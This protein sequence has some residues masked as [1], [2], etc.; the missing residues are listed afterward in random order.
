M[1]HLDDLAEKMP[2]IYKGYARMVKGSL[3]AALRVLKVDLKKGNKIMMIGEILARGI[4]SYGTYKAV[5]QHNE[6]I[7]RYVEVKRSH[8][9][10]NIDKIRLLHEK[11][12]RMIST[13]QKFFS[14]AAE[15]SYDFRNK[16]EETIVGQSNLTLRFL[17]LYRTNL[18]LLEI[19]RYLLHEFQAWS[20]GSHSSEE[21]MPGYFSVN[22]R[23]VLY[24]F[25]ENAFQAFEQATESDGVLSGAEIMML[26]DPQMCA[27]ILR[28]NLCEFIA[29]EASVP[30]RFLLENN[31]GFRLYEK[32]SVVAIR[33]MRYNPTLIVDLLCLAAVAGIILLGILFFP[34]G[35]LR[36]WVMSVGV[37]AVLRIDIKNRMKAKIVHIEKVSGIIDAMNADLAVYC[38]YVEQPSMDY[39]KKN[40]IKESIKTFFS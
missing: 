26:A 19:S 22:G 25:G 39:E 14:K 6:L 30:V 13:S 31:E 37:A 35:A 36:W 8:A 23:I 15:V 29:Q 20:E 21:I 12:E 16:T 7:D 18:F 1:Q 11:M 28:G 4:E 9:S 38:G 5:K 17:T 27:F 2:E 34:H 33:E 32:N 24:L 40:E 3:D 10:H